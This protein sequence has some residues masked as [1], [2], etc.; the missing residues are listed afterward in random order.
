[1]SFRTSFGKIWKL[2]DRRT[3]DPEKYADEELV[4]L[5]Q[6]KKE[7][8][9]VAILMERYLPQITAFGYRHLKNKEH[10]KDFTHDLFLK[11]CDRLRNADITNFKSW[12]FKVMKNMF[13]DQVKH[14]KVI[15]KYRQH[16]AVQIQPEQ[17]EA[18][19]DTQMDREHLHRA[20]ENL[21][22]KEKLCI[23]AIYLEEKSY[24]EVSDATGLTFNQIRGI[25]ERAITK[26]RDALMKIYK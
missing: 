14:H 3:E 11:L 19:L 12:L 8:T 13:L 9:Y 22:A 25:R 10:T 5:F 7:T 2:P 18:V 24:K 15:L 23:R 21:N 17:G 20:L 16:Q 1:M 6:Q 26:M 4:S